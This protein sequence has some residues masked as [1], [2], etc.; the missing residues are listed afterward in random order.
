MSEV[1]TLVGRIAER[2]KRSHRMENGFA[3]EWLEKCAKHEQNHFHRLTKWKKQEW[4]V[5]MVEEAHPEDMYSFRKWSKG[6]RQYPMPAIDRPGQT[7]ATTHAE[8]CK[9]LRD[10][11]YQ[12]PPELPDEFPIN[13][14]D[15]LPGDIPFQDITDTEVAEAIADTSNT[16]AP[17]FSVTGRIKSTCAEL[18]IVYKD[19]S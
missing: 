17:G 9:A 1:Q 19:Y 12:P 18:P 4:A 2:A 6:G 8:K 15:T 13:L 3:S 16:S 14:T 11:L 7:P 10:E 5:K